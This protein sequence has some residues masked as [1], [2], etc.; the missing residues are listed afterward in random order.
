MRHSPPMMQT[1]SRCEVRTV[2]TVQTK[3][4]G[5]HSNRPRAVHQNGA[6]QTGVGQI[7]QGA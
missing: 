4:C 7:N 2:V 6:S 3:M 5:N 1:A